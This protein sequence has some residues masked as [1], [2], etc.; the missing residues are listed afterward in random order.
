MKQKRVNKLSSVLLILSMMLVFSSV[1]VFAASES[2]PVIIKQP[3]D[4][5][6]EWGGIFRTSVEAEG[7][8]LTYQWYYKERT[9]DEF[10]VSCMKTKTYSVGVT[11][12]NIGRQ[13]Y[14]VITDANGKT[15]T[16]D[17]V[18]FICSNKIVLGKKL[19][20]GKAKLGEQVAVTAEAYGDGLTYQWYYK[21]PYMKEFAKSCKTT[22]VYSLPM[23][24][25]THGRQLY[26]V[27]A[28]AM[29]NTVTT[30]TVKLIRTDLAIIKQPK[31]VEAKLGEIASV[32]VEATGDELKYQWYYKDPSMDDFAV[33]S[34]KTA[35]YSCKMTVGGAG[36]Q[37]YCVITDVSGKKKITDIVTMKRKQA[38]QLKII[39]QPVDA[40]V[41]VGEMATITMK[42][43]GE[44]LKYQWYYKEPYM[45]EFAK[46]CVTKA[47]YSQ[48]MTAYRDG[49]EYYCVITDVFGNQVT[50]KTVKTI[51]TD[52]VLLKQPQNTT[53]VLNERFSIGMDV[54]GE[55]LTYQWYYKDSYMKEFKE[56]SIKSS[57]YS[58]R[59]MNYV[60]G[61]QVYCVITDKFGNEI[62]TKAVEI[63]L[64]N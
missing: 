5:K 51:R 34:I 22:A 38:I 32:T 55:G 26:C 29:G 17:T 14:C 21:D 23:V 10:A 36:R 49:R 2:E 3:V 37:I 48:V 1:T 39:E 57:T 13:V 45:E 20:D 30:N 60:D 28:D 47:E 35:T 61:R 62:T 6:A 25:Y 63:S 40:K 56:S 54:R 7:E 15:V 9:M 4:V 16:S 42:V 31:D 27:V 58:L 46:S 41:K 59:M 43:Q 12:S 64:A 44:G 53:C 8:G 18:E 24:T 52:F 11:E 33:S 50:T 19:V